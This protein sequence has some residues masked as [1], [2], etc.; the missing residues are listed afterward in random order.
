MNEN[1]Q[2]KIETI[3]QY[4]LLIFF[5]GLF[6]YLIQSFLFVILFAI[7]IVIASY[8]IYEKILSKIKRPVLA[9][10]TIILLFSIIIILPTYL[11]SLKLYQDSVDF[12]VNHGEVLQNIEL[13]NCEYETCDTINS[14]IELI[15]NSVSNILNSIGSSLSSYLYS[16][17]TSISNFVIQIF[18]FYVCLFYFYLDKERFLK[19]FKKLVPLKTHYKEALIIKFKKVCTAVF[20]DTL[21]IAIMQGTLVGIG[22]YIFGLPS[23]ILWGIVASFLALLPFIGSGFVWITASIYLIISGDYFSGVGFLIYGAVIVSFSDNLIRPYLLEKSIHI[24]PFLILLSIMGGIKVFG[25]LGIFYGPIIISMLVALIELY[26]I[27][28]K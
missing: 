26:E 17:I 11:I 10:A 19:T 18:I 12:Y 13:K 9:S 14:N 15:T 28:F 3:F 24:H 22:F 1:A 20:L 6:L 4:V 8:S 16:F 25:F 27:N 23:G 5:L 2:L 21:L 7:A